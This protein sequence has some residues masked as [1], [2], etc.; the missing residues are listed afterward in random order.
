M[1]TNIENLAGYGRIKSYA[2]FVYLVIY[3]DVVAV[4]VVSVIRF[5]NLNLSI[6]LE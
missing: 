1:N 2:F 6:M 5:I 3:F 4:G